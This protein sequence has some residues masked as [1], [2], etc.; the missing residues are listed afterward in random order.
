MKKAFI[1][2][3]ES[4]KTV[5][6]VNKKIKDGCIKIGKKL[7]FVDKDNAPI[8]PRGVLI[9]SF[10]P[11]FLLKWNT[12]VELRPTDTGL[13]AGQ[14][15]ENLAKFVENKTLSLLLTPKKNNLELIIFLVVGAV[16]GG[17]I[18]YLAA[19]GKFA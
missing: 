2:Y 15:A 18:G 8:V 17:I 9:K 6:V 12:P 4:D 10:R 19:G 7:F 16:L 5:R 3:F 1:I 13:R 14:S 11:L